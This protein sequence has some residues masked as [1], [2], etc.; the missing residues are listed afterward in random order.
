MSEER[1]LIDDDRKILSLAYVYYHNNPMNTF[2][3][4]YELGKHFYFILFI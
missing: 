3:K 2:N 1:F 4:I